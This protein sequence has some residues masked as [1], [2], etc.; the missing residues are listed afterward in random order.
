MNRTVA[1]SPEADTTYEGLDVLVWGACGFIG[2]NLVSALL[3]RGARVSV[4]TRT[5][6]GYPHQAWQD[7]VRWFELAGDPGDVTVLDAAVGGASVIFN[8]AGSTGAAQSNRAP[9]DSLDANNR[10]QLE[11]L[12]ACRR[13][14]QRPHVVFT[15]SRLVY[16]R[17]R[18]PRVDETHPIEP[19]SIYAAHKVCCEHYHAIYGAQGAI[20]RT[21]VRVS[22][23][24][25]L[26][27]GSVRKPHGALNAFVQQT[28]AGQPLTIFGDG[29]QLRDYLFIDDLAEALLACGVREAARN[30]IINIGGGC[31][32]SLRHAAERIVGALG[33]P[34]I[35]YVPWPLDQAMVETGDYV[36]DLGKAERLLDFAPRHPFDAALSVALAAIRGPRVRTTRVTA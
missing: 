10:A 1:V 25:G 14:G 8:L 36:T 19:A 26:D 11:F 9:L 16:G 6:S 17:P 13:A 28:L 27:E 29:S 7:R 22:N 34:A 15:S 31:P 35:V 2:R 4:L 33:G 12:E 32:I 5:R 3:E 18:T 23:A 20:S 21:I 30:E 24:F